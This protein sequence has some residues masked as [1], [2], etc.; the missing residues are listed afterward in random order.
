[1]GE[2]AGKRRKKYVDYPNGRSKTTCIINGSG[3]LSDEFNVL[4]DFCFRYT[5]NRPT[6]ESGHDP[7]NRK[8]LCRQQVNNSIVISAVDEIL[9]YE[10]QIESADKGEHVNI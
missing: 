4:R 1:M 5:K 10:N 3:N 2:S 9:L 6:K 8:K 7:I